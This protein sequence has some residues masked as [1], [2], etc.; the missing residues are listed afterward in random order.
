LVR[1]VVSLDGRILE[2]P[3]DR[4]HAVE[5]L[6]ALSGRT[7]AHPPCPAPSGLWAVIAICLCLPLCM[8]S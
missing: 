1:Q 5:M 3:R 7:C 6:T 2:K 4:A 8:A